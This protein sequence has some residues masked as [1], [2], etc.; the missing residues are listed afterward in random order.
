M[1]LNKSLV[2]Q[3]PEQR[4]RSA[5][6]IQLRCFEYPGL[7][8]LN[9]KRLLSSIRFVSGIFPDPRTHPRLGRNGSSPT[10]VRSSEAALSETRSF[11]ES[12]SIASNN[13]DDSA[14][15]SKNK[16]FFSNTDFIFPRKIQLKTFF[17]IVRFRW[18]TFCRHNFARRRFFP[19]IVSYRVIM[20]MKWCNSRHC[21]LTCWWQLIIFNS[22]FHR[23]LD[24]RRFL[25]KNAKS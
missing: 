19:N 8:L 18:K 21:S 7:L 9:S 5:W 25:G 3:E 17:E 10:F 6:V 24:P 1:L 11:P 2:Q 4:V 15:N 23:T 22:W 13:F 16:L 14:S 20:I 12:E